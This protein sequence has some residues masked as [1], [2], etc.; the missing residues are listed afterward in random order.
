VVSR[1]NELLDSSNLL[2]DEVGHRPVL[3]GTANADK[4]S[5]KL[6]ASRSVLYFGVP[7]DGKDGLG[8]MGDTSK[9]RVLGCLAKLELVKDIQVFPKLI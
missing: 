6:C 8:F 2:V 7:L 4:V 5:E 3:L 9:W 1:S